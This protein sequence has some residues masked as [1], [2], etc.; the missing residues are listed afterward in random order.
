MKQSELDSRGSD[1]LRIF[2]FQGDH[3]RL[4]LD[5]GWAKALKMKYRTNQMTYTPTV[6]SK[7]FSQVPRHVRAAKFRNFSN[8]NAMQDSAK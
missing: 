6:L 2:L 5:N 7:I 1:F 8:C 3:F 4:P